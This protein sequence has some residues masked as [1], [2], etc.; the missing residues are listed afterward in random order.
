MMGI[1]AES[2]TGEE[3]RWMKISMRKEGNKNEWENKGYIN[4][5]GT[6]AQWAGTGDSSLFR[7]LTVSVN[8]RS[9]HTVNERAAIKVSLDTQQ[10]AVH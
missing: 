9:T 2:Q 10:V 4:M 1:K 6:H 3:K 5:Q 8:T 7:S